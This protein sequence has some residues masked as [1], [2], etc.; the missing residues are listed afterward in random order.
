MVISHVVV[1]PEASSALFW[2]HIIN[3]KKQVSELTVA[4]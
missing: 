4:A 3:E 1:G 2:A